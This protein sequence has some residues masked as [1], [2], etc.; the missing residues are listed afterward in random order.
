MLVFLFASPSLVAD[1][2]TLAKAKRTLLTA[3]SRREGTQAI[4]RAVADVEA[5]GAASA[6]TYAS[7]R[8]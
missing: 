8:S 5:L 3:V 1:S 4:L 6:S 2:S 7:S